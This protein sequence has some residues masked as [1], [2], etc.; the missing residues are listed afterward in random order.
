MTQEVGWAQNPIN[1]EDSTSEANESTT[2][3]IECLD[4]FSFQRK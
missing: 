4:L 1:L 2:S 3:T